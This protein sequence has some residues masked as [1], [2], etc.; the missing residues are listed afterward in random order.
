MASVAARSST[1]ESSG[2]DQR[3]DVGAAVLGGLI[4]DLFDLDGEVAL[5]AE[6]QE[7]LEGVVT[8]GDLQQHRQGEATAHHDLFDV[9]DGRAHRVEHAEQCRWR[10][11]V[12]RVR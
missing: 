7:I 11:R 1:G 4:V 8:V 2:P 9:D 10:C 6:Q 3:H 5:E 12:R